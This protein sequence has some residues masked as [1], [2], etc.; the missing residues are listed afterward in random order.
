MRF[1]AKS[2]HSGLE[3]LYR[4]PLDEFFHHFNELLEEVNR[5]RS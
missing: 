3:E 2:T 5:D 1:V 4:M